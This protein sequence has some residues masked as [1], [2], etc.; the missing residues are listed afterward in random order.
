MMRHD[1][2]EARRITSA[3][4]GASNFRFSP[5]GHRLVFRSGEQGKQQL[6]SLPVAELGSA[7]SEAI[8]DEPAGIESWEFSPDGSRIYFTR[9]DSFVTAET[10]ASRWTSRTGRPPSPSSTP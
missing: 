7:E 1:G 4:E 6:H 8:T 5:D 9:P 2:G 10:R 3:A